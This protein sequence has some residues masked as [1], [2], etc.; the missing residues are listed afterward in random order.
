MHLPAAISIPAQQS[1]T[2]RRLECVFKRVGA[3][4]VQSSQAKCG[5]PI[6]YIDFDKLFWRITLRAAT[7]PSCVALQPRQETDQEEGRPLRRVFFYGGLSVSFFVCEAFRRATFKQTRT[8]EHTHTNTQMCKR[9]K[10]CVWKTWK[11]WFPQN[12]KVT[13]TLLDF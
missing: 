3:R 10:E 13:K 2:W 1:V 12:W 8:H 11:G 6:S 5:R 7:G 4:S 9:S